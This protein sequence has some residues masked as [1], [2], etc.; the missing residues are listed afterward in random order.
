MQ[1]LHT[2][3]YSWIPTKAEDRRRYAM[4]KAGNCILNCEVN[5][6]L[7]KLTEKS[8]IPRQTKNSPCKFFLKDAS[9][10]FCDST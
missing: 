8:H 9:L 4:R 7:G 2:N 10:N 1:Q 5:L 3:Q 6:N